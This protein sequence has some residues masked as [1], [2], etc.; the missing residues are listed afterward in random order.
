MFPIRPVR[1]A[2]LVAALLCA[3]HAVAGA[4]KPL[5]PAAAFRPV[6]ACAPIDPFADASPERQERSLGCDADI[7]LAMAVRTPRLRPTDTGPN[8]VELEVDRQV[9]LQGSYFTGVARFGMTAASDPA[10]H[11]LQP[12]R[13]LVAASGTIRLTD[14]FAMDL[15][16]GRDLLPARSRVTATAIYRPEGRHLMYLQVAEEAGLLAPA[17]GLR[18]WLIPGGASLDVSAR[19]AADDSIEP[20]VGLRWSQ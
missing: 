16:L 3:C 4:E 11:R 12:R 20:R 18:W 2:A 9:S 7:P 6:P 14:D 10:D 13:N 15:G 5:L 19:R 1:G 17:V 8:A